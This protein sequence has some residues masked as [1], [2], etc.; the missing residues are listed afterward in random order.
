MLH[1]ADGNID[2]YSSLL[3]DFQKCGRATRAH[4]SVSVVELFAP[5]VGRALGAHVVTNP[6]GEYSQIW[7][8]DEMYAAMRGLSFDCPPCQ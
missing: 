8:Y 7:G 5:V 1:Q 2:S 4:L 6:E 3:I